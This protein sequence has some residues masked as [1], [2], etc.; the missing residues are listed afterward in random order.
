MADGSF[1]FEKLD[2]WQKAMAWV[3]LMY[4]ASRSFPET[5]R[6]CLQSQLRRAAVSVASNIA[7][8][9]GRGTNADFVRFIEMTY[10]SLMEAVCQCQIAADL[11]YIDSDT[12]EQL[13][14]EAV[15]IGRMLTGLRRH[16]LSDKANR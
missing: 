15:A 11:G 2:V 12:H 8:G 5:E 10:G 9:T 13:R 1:R 16:R 3:Q 6:Y 4:K 14:I 7:E